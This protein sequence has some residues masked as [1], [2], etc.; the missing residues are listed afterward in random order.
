MPEGYFVAS[1]QAASVGDGER[2]R[3]HRGRAKALGYFTDWRRRAREFTGS[4]GAR[5]VDLNLPWPVA[6]DGRTPPTF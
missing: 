6:A 1:V 2:E 5:G 3:S 4:G